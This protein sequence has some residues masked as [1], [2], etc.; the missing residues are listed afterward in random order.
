MDPGA[1]VVSLAAIMLAL[2]IARL[3]EHVQEVLQADSKECECFASNNGY[4]DY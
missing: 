1:S 4:P 2:R 3:E